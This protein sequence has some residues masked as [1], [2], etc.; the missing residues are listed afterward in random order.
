MSLIGKWWISPEG[1]FDGSDVEHMQ[2]ATAYMLDLPKDRHVPNWWTIRG[3]PIEELDAAAKRGVSAKTLEFLSNK[4]NDARLW[5]MREFGWVRTA[6]NKWSVWFFDDATADMVRD[7]KDYWKFQADQ[8]KMTEHEMLDVYEFKDGC[9]YSISV[10]KLLEGGRP[11]VLKKL[12]MGGLECSG[13]EEAIAPQYSTAKYSEL[14]RQKLY[15][16]SGANPRR[17]RK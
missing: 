17:S 9:E 12:A 5:V 13:K 7:A 1:S 16:I 10:Q 8:G 11:Q 14:E 2:L 3:I 6:K 4:G 15:G